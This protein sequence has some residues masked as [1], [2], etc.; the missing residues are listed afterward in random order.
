MV[1][2]ETRNEWPLRIGFFD[3]KANVVDQIQSDC[4]RQVVVIGRWLWGHVW[5]FCM[6]E[7]EPL[8]FFLSHRVVKEASLYNGDC[9]TTLYPADEVTNFCDCV[10]EWGTSCAERLDLTAC[11]P[12]ESK[13]SFWTGEDITDVMKERAEAPL[14]CDPSS[15]SAYEYDEN[16]V[17]VEVFS[18]P[19]AS[20]RSEENVTT[21][22]TDV[23]SGNPVSETCRNI[24]QAIFDNA[25]QSCIE[26][27]QVRYFVGT[28]FSSQSA[29]C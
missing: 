15:A 7:V 25:L 19:T 22:C 10:D 16:Y 18:W 9:S 13:L 20:N 27:I 24:S 8:S 17:A 12:I 23:L 26:N 29:D 5:L 2:Q 14:A 11:R 4:I 28:F 1:T 6:H 3:G 21:I